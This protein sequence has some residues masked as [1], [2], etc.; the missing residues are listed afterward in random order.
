[1][2]AEKNKSIE[3]LRYFGEYF[4]QNSDLILS[5]AVP[6]FKYD[7]ALIRIGFLTKAFCCLAS[8][9]VRGNSR[10]VE[11]LKQEL[12]SRAQHEEWTAH[13]RISFSTS[14]AK[15]DPQSCEHPWSYDCDMCRS[16]SVNYN[17][18]KT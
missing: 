10:D 7:S 9:T 14:Q 2:L 4:P 11:M 13:S 3:N 12:E 17:K 18:V 5:E 8:A 15:T 6:R 1:V 16:L